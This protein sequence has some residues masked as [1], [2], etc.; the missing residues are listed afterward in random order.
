LATPDCLG[1]TRLGSMAITVH[2]DVLDQAARAINAAASLLG[3]APINGSISINWL[4]DLRAIRAGSA[5]APGTGLLCV[6]ED[7]R[8]PATSSA[9]ASCGRAYLDQIAVRELLDR[10]KDEAVTGALLNSCTAGA[11]PTT[12]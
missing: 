11:S 2:Q 4:A 1:S 12:S 5:V 9:P 6:L 3:T 10:C 7:R 8:I